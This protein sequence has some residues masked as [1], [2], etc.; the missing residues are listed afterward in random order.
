[1]IWTNVEITCC[2]EATNKDH[3]PKT[4]KKRRKC[5]ICREEHPTGL[6]G[7]QRSN[8]IRGVDHQA[9]KETFSAYID[10]EK[11]SIAKKSLVANCTKL[12]AEM[13]SLSIVPVKIT[14]PESST[15]VI[16]ALLDNGSQGTA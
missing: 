1:M 5:E 3:F 4:C 6:H 13:I 16:N 7:Y 15:V 11:G 8:V 10:G 12:I 9:R 2:Y 14:H